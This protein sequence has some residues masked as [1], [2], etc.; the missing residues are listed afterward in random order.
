M[1]DIH[2]VE[3]KDAV[4]DILS[5][6]VSSDFWELLCQVLDD[7][8][9]AQDE[10]INDEDVMDLDPVQYKTTMEILKGRKSDLQKLKELPQK[11]ILD[12]QDP[13]QTE[14]EFDPYEKK[15]TDAE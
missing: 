1:I 5:Q 2:D 10:Q 12:L 14:P 15:A 3:N 9:K 7:N 4:R 6:G 11:I 13:N 8:I